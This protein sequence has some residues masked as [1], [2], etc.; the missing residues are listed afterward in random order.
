MSRVFQKSRDKRRE[1]WEKAEKFLAFLISL[2]FG[3]R[4]SHDLVNGNFVFSPS[5]SLPF[6][7]LQMYHNPLIKM[8]RS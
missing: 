7:A 8:I 5:V 6:Y 3:N 1:K 2:L 4:D